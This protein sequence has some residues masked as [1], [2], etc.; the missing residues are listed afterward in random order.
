MS[1]LIDRADAFAEKSHEGQIRRYTGEPYVEH[2][3]RVAAMVRCLTDDPEVI[4]AALLH[5]VIEDCDVTIDDIVAEFG[6]R[7][8]RLVWEL[9]DWYP[10]IEGMCRAERKGLEADRLGGCSWE[11][12]L[13]KICDIIDN[14]PS[15][16][17]HGGDFA[18]VWKAE[19][20]HLV[21][22]LMGTR[23]V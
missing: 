22:K 16:E 18:K 3:R 9:T 11:A 13:V 8:A 15:I 1:D 21:H 23:H 5:D 6:N 4:A 12:R 19:K 7:V 20:V 10:S 17:E 14:A 2:P